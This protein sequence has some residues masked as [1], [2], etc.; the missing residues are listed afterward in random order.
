VAGSLALSASA[1]RFLARRQLGLTRRLEQLF[2]TELGSRLGAYLLEYASNDG[3][4]LPTNSE[5]AS[6]IGTVPELVS[7]KLGEFYRLG[8]I[9]LERR[10]VWVVDSR[11]LRD[12]VER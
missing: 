6:L 8:W 2:F 5:L 12:L 3:F 10:R 11:A 9:R 7:R 4:A 1:I